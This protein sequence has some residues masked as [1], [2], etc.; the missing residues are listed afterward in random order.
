MRAPGMNAVSH[1]HE[2]MSV[3]HEC[4]LLCAAVPQRLAALRRMPLVAQADRA[5][6]SLNQPPPV[7]FKPAEVSIHAC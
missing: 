4:T 6:G 5:E 7:F 3:M 2:R 1:F